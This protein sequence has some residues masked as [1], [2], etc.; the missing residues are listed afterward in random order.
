MTI[1]T[2]LVTAKVV[3]TSDIFDRYKQYT[4]LLGVDGLLSVI[5][6]LIDIVW[7]KYNSCLPQMLGIQVKTPTQGESASTLPASY[8]DGISMIIKNKS[9]SNFRIAR[10]TAVMSNC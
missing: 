4:T 6:S 7:Q 3:T 8:I 10:G 9:Y 2:S 1:Y 5:H